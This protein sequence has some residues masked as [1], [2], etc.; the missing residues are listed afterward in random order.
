MSEQYQNSVEWISALMEETMVDLRN[1][2]IE[3]QYSEEIIEDAITKLQQQYASPGIRIRVIPAP[4]K[5]KTTVKKENESLKWITHPGDNT[6]SYTEDFSLTNGIP[7][8][9]NK[10][11]VIIGAIDNDGI[12]ELITQDIATCARYGCKAQITKI[13]F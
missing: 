13:D 10:T 5:K 6:F 1:T 3:N 9:N 7:L 2:F 12:Q 11:Y 8:R 4:A